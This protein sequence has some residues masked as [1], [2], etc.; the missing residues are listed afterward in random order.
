MTVGFL[1]GYSVDQLWIL[2][3]IVFPAWLGIILFPKHRYS[4]YLVI[5]VVLI[6]CSLYTL[7]FIT[8]VRQDGF[9]DFSSK[10]AVVALFKD[11]EWVFIG[12][13]HFLVFDLLIGLWVSNDALITK[14]PQLVVGICLAITLWAGPMGLGVYLIIRTLISKDKQKIF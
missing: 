3:N 8:K 11:P 1:F 7:G 10:T 2:S 14:V 9:P 5:S 13:I 4:R 6:I 12:W